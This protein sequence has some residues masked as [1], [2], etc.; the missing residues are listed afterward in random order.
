LLIA[1]KRLDPFTIKKQ[2]KT[3]QL[4]VAVAEKNVVEKI[5]NLNSWMR[6]ED[7]FNFCR[8]NMVVLIPKV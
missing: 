3:I 6:L 2:I 5:E 4:F 7:F 8:C 1:T